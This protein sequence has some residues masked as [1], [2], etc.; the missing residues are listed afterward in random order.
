MSLVEMRN[1]GT[2]HAVAVMQLSELLMRAAGG[3]AKVRVQLPFSASEVS[4]PEPDIAVVPPGNYEGTHPAAAVLVVEV[5]VESL[6]KD[7]HLKAELYARAGVPE[8]WI[9]NL[10][11]R[12]I[13]V[14]AQPLQGTYTKVETIAAGGFVP[15]APFEAAI[16]VSDVLG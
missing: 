14:H 15:L 8:Y 1:Q 16:A 9:V 11:D 13:E 2:A 10:V 5:A 3:R 4:L 7:R 6:R 12:C